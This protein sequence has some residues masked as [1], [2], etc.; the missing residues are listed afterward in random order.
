MIFRV[1]IGITL[2]FSSVVYNVECIRTYY[3]IDYCGKEIS[4]IQKHTYTG[5]LLV[6]SPDFDKYLDCLVTI[7]SWYF[8]PYIA[9]HFEQ[10]SFDTSDC[11]NSYVTFQD[12]N[13]D[14]S[15]SVEGMMNTTCGR[16][17]TTNVF[18]TTT[19][20]LRIHYRG[21][22]SKYHFSIIFNCY[23]KGPCDS[24]EYECNSGWCINDE[25]KCNGFNPC[26]DHS[27]CHLKLSSGA[28]VGIV[29]GCIILVG[30]S[31]SVAICI[32]CCLRKK[33]GF[34]GTV[35]CVSNQPVVL[36]SPDGQQPMTTM[37][38]CQTNNQQLLTSQQP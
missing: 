14:N 27:D 36:Y 2:F 30:I 22:P 31:V 25:L 32:Y 10:V 19:R 23:E 28:V 12:G 8:N 5:K 13:E 17:K 34:K 20:Y 33:K 6:A 9:F 1:V 11:T 4:M 24:Y 35:T 18:S 3:M 15:P 37:E 7:E 38:T 16:N 21:N 29:V 26:G